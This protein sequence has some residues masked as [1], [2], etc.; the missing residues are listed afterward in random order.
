MSW[1]L[2]WAECSGYSHGMLHPQMTP[3]CA[4]PSER[5]HKVFKRWLR[6]QHGAWQILFSLLSHHMPSW[7]FSSSSF[8]VTQTPRRV[9]QATGQTLAKGVYTWVYQ[10]SFF[11]FFTLT[12]TGGSSL[13]RWL[14]CTGAT[15]SAK[16]RSNASLSPVKICRLCCN[17]LPFI[18][19]MSVLSLAAASFRTADSE[20]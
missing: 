1:I 4:G 7:C 5:S 11:C 8:W 13:R 3:G 9:A 14:G 12:L 10:C 19:I 6:A 20:H 15:G 18:N 17:V 16:Q 2:T